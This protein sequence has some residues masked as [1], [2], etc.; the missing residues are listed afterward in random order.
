MNYK[1]SKKY[2]KDINNKINKINNF[3]IVV[4]IMK[5]LYEHCFNSKWTKDVK[6]GITLASNEFNIRLEKVYN[7]FDVPLEEGPNGIYVPY[8]KLI[9]PHIMCVVFGYLALKDIIDVDEKYFEAPIVTYDHFNNFD[10]GLYCKIINY[11]F[12][13]EFNLDLCISYTLERVNLEL[14]N[15]NDKNAKMSAIVDYPNYHIH[16]RSEMSPE[17]IFM[18]MNNEG[19]C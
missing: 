8:N 4:E 6:N 1:D 10:V 14:T 15:K 18:Y 12:E 11:L 2:K 16:K 3:D 13:N 5:K 7:L 9:T 19:G 17:E